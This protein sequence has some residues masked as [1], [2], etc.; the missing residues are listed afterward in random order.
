MQNRYLMCSIRYLVQDVKY[1]CTLWDVYLVIFD[2]LC[3]G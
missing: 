1:L 2:S 3:I